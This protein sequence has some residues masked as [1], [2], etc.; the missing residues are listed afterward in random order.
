MA[1]KKQQRQIPRETLQARL[2]GARSTLIVMA[3]LSVFN[4]VMIV[5]DQAYQISFSATLPCNLVALGKGMDNGNVNGAWTVVG[6]Y[7]AT[8][9]VLAAAVLAV[10]VVSWLL[11]KKHLGWLITALVLVCVD[12]V[13]LV[14]FAMMGGDTSVIIDLCL[15]LWVIWLLIQGVSARRKLEDYEI[16]D[17]I[18]AE[19]AAAQ[20]EAWKAKIDD[21]RQTPPSEKP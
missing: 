19:E 3:A 16:L 7:T 10:Y 14:L 21:A 9:L 20:E 1:T 18:R 11:S 13:T 6:V 4:I 8:S 15:H 5:L 2:T 17:R 12:T